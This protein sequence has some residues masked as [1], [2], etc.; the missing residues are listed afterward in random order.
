MGKLRGVYRNT[1]DID[2]P[3][4]W[5]P[6]LVFSTVLVVVSIGALFT[7][8]LNLAID[9]RGGSVWEVP[10]KTMTSA[11]ALD[12]LGQFNK[13]NGAKVQVATD[14]KGTRILRIQADSTDIKQSQTIADAY[15]KKA[16]IKP[17]DVGTNTVGP[18][19]G[20]EITKQ[21][22]KSLVIFLVL[23]TV[24]ISWQLEWRMAVAA[25]VAV[26]HDV[27][28]T[29]GIYALFQFEVTPATVISFLTI[30]GY[31]L[32]DTIVV[33]DRVQE[34]SAR[35]DRSGQ[36]TYTG[37]MRRSMNQVLMRSVNTTTVSLLPVASMLLIGSLAFNQPIIGDF[38]LALF[39]GLLSGAYSSIFIA[40]PVVVYLKEREPKYRRVRSRA[41]ERGTLAQ[42]EHI[43]VGAAAH[44]APPMFG[45]STPSGG[46]TVAAAD[47]ATV[48]ATVQAHKASQY[49][50]PHPPRPRKQKRR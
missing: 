30:L 27:I 3:K 22:G 14:A 40:A 37:I 44:A 46:A 1:N 42:A 45:G 20:S 23:I 34:N 50:R 29:I 38:S 15:A 11:Q 17:D 4:I 36:Y 5:K 26:L 43:P 28:V 49:Q 21:A 19:W 13:E 2:F 39:I 9:F 35:Y 32:Y 24:Y 6:V 25:L 8:G 7:R 48:T 10:S 18:S 12:V 47:G 33:Y 31:S 16:N 41:E